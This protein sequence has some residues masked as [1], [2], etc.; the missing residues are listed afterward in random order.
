[1]ADVARFTELLFANQSLDELLV[2]VDRDELSFQENVWTRLIEAAAC[3]RRNERARASE[4]L[5]E[6]TANP[7]TETRVLLWSW[8]TLR[9]LGVHPQLDAAAQIKGVVIQVPMGNG[10][11]VLAA[12]ADGTARYVNHSG[13]VVVWDLPDAHIGNIIR[14]VIERAKDLA[15]GVQTAAAAQPAE[16]VVRVTVLTPNGNRS[17]GVPMRALGAGPINQLLA[18]GAELM[19]NLIKRTE[20]MNQLMP[21]SPGTMLR[22]GH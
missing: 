5:L 10:I 7:N 12:Y 6:I 15:T 20:A 17:L 4:L 1:M 19:G 8:T 14:T 2:S 22:R 16:D 9:E 18:V 13:K 3:L 21:Q 11:D